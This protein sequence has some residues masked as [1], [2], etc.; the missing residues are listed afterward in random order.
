MYVAQLGI[1]GVA[2]EAERSNFNVNGWNHRWTNS[3]RP[4]VATLGGNRKGEAVFRPWP[5]P[6]RS[7]FLRCWC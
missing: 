6:R 3:S 2:V 7:L 5:P 1:G 4:V